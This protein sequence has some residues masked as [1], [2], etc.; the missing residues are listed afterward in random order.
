MFQNSALVI[1]ATH[2]LSR[3]LD[4]RK[5]QSGSAKVYPSFALPVRRA[6]AS[7]IEDQA[8]AGQAHLE[9]F[10][11]HFGRRKPALDLLPT[12]GHRHR[13]RRTDEQGLNR[14]TRRSNPCA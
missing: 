12:H 6:N 3:S 11:A 7:A 9:P 14:N 5:S 2:E 4:I 1:Q 10:A 8:I 13:D